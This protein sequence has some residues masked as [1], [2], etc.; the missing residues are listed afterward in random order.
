M[1]S[2]ELDPVNN[3]EDFTWSGA[4]QASAI[5]PQLL[6]IEVGLAIIFDT[7]ITYIYSLLFWN[8]LKFILR[9]VLQTSWWVWRK[10]LLTECSMLVWNSTRINLTWIYII[11][12]VLQVQTLLKDPLLERYHVLNLV[13]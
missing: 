10:A 11:K 1:A 8:T 13:L 6:D 2:G 3:I 7:V 4:L 12:M 5:I 9:M